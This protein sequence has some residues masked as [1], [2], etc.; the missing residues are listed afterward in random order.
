MQDL[1]ITVFYF[2]IA[3]K[4]KDN[5]FRHFMCIAPDH[6]AAKDEFLKELAHDDIER[7]DLRTLTSRGRTSFNANEDTICVLLDIYRIDLPEDVELF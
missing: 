7:Y 5:A 3:E 1:R 6:N 2:C 4:T